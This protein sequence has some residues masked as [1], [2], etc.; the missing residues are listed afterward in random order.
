MD[1]QEKYAGKNIHKPTME[2]RHS[3]LGRS[4][5]SVYRSVCPACEHGVLPVQRDTDTMELM[6]EDR[7]LLCGQRFTYSDIGEVV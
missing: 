2:V 6:A 7:C 1:A 5:A 3:E 4:D